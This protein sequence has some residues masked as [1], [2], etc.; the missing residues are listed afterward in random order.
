MAILMRDIFFQSKVMPVFGDGDK[1]YT[2]YSHIFRN[3]RQ[4]TQQGVLFI[5]FH[6]SL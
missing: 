1:K 4:K 2:N 5:L 6:F 3:S